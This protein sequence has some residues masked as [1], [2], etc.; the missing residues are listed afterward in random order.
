MDCILFQCLRRCNMSDVLQ[1]GIALT[2]VN[3]NLSIIR[4]IPG[5]IDS[6]LF[7]LHQCQNKLAPVNC[8]HVSQSFICHNT[9]AYHLDDWNISII[10]WINNKCKHIN[11]MILLT[12]S[13][14][15]PDKQYTSSVHSWD[16]LSKATSWMSTVSSTLRKNYLKLLK[17]IFN[18]AFLSHG[19]Y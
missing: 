5:S 16:F 18:I 13:M 4:K 6:S 15:A 2:K 1:L 8:S 11:Q 3:G 10:F 9:I 12:P 7:M 19:T 14:A 17:T